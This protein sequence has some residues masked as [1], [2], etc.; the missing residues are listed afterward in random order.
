MWAV[1][2]TPTVISC[3][4]SVANM[5]DE[6]SPQGRATVVAPGMNEPQRIELCRLIRFQ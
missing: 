5:L 3:L 6:L 4:M 2:E 1:W